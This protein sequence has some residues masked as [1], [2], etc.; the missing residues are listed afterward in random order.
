MCRIASAV[1]LV[2]VV[3]GGCGGGS[4]VVSGGRVVT[5]NPTE[6]MPFDEVASL[7]ANAPAV[8]YLNRRGTTVEEYPC[9]I[10][11]VLS[12]W[13]DRLI[14]CRMA[15]EIVGQGDSGSPV[16]LGGEVVGALAMGE[17]G[18]NLSFLARPIEDVINGVTSADGAE[19]VSENSLA[20]VRF[21]SGAT[22]ELATIAE[23]NGFLVLP[24][25]GEVGMSLGDVIAGQSLSVNTLSGDLITAGAIGTAT[26][27][28]GDKVY[29]FGHGYNEEGASAI[30]VTLAR[31]V[32]FYN[33][34]TTLFGGGA[35]KLA[36]PTSAEVGTLVDDRR[37]GVVIDRSAS[38]NVY[39]IVTTVTV[40]GEKRTFQHRMAHGQFGYWDKM[41]IT[42]GVVGTVAYL[43]DTANRPAHVRAV[44]M[45][46]R[47]GFSTPD[48]FDIRE[49]P[50]GGGGSD[51]GLLL[52]NPIFNIFQW[53]ASSLE[54]LPMGVGPRWIRADI[55]ITE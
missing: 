4:A 42:Y 35:H 34:G 52:R 44:M 43:Y 8:V 9:T 12:D 16:V 48:R 40:G 13:G 37:Y 39:P 53:V 5:E 15:S 22:G 55:E 32:D 18:E 10:K 20:P 21:V 27:C 29:A 41:M 11:G 47:E 28:R 50:L 49:G 3:M 31:M 54:G 25:G 45:L 2:V 14:A 1:L 38:A 26:F 17:A 23:D 6:I 7:P 33:A 36:T 46:K 19:Y 51:P 24:G 30:P